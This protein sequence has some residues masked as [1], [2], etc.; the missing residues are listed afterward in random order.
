MCC[1]LNA[2]IREECDE[3]PARTL[4]CACVCYRRLWAQRKMPLKIN[5]P[6][7]VREK[8]IT[9]RVTKTLPCEWA[10]AN[11]ITVVKQLTTP[12]TQHTFPLLPFN[13]LYCDCSV[14]YRARIC[15]THIRVPLYRASM[16]AKDGMQWEWKRRKRVWENK[17]A[18]ECIS[19]QISTSPMS[20]VAIFPNTQTNPQQS[21]TTFS[22]L[23]ANER[24]K[25]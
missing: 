21:T 15:A 5:T 7:R 14:L 8:Q 16:V 12:T 3:W 22:T 4:C 2:C 10:R 1:V 19:T 9:E 18:N 24:M 23:R 20:F 17:W 11:A 13:V 25:K 6:K